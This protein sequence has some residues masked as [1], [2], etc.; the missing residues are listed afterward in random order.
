MTVKSDTQVG[1][2]A[3]VGSTST[4]STK[5]KATKANMPADE[6]PFAAHPFC[7]TDKVGILDPDGTSPNPLTGKPYIN[8]LQT[9]ML[10]NGDFS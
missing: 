3:K 2:A 6:V 4:T 1:H 9:K 7:I 8:R 10:K 5:T